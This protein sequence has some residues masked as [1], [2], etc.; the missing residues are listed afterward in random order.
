MLEYDFFTVMFDYNSWKKQVRMKTTTNYSTMWYF[1]SAVWI[2]IWIHSQT[3]THVCC[4]ATLMATEKTIFSQWVIYVTASGLTSCN[5]QLPV[6]AS[7]SMLC[8][9]S[10]DLFHLCSPVPVEVVL[11][12]SQIVPLHPVVTL[13]T[14]CMTGP[15]L[16]ISDFLPIVQWLNFLRI[17]IRQTLLIPKGKCR[18]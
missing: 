5:T 4:P 8:L 11:Q 6:C 17:K 10:P 2:I 9:W 7:P 18:P 15:A 12:S 1:Y 13:K 14:C 16:Q 3:Q